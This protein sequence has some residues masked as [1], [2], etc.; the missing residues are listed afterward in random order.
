MKSSNETLVAQSKQL[1]DLMEYI[2]DIQNDIPE[3]D[4]ERQIAATSAIISVGISME[5]NAINKRLN[6]LEDA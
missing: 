5:L 1:R 2:T 4:T 6:D 3:D